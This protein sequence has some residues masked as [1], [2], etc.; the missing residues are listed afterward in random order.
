VIL[1]LLLQ[2]ADHIDNITAHVSLFVQLLLL[3]LSLCFQL[4]L[5]TVFAS[6]LVT[7]L[8]HSVVVVAHYSMCVCVLQRYC[9]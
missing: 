3:L 9:Y 5:T 7:V 6:L 8:L 1:L 2:L 4:L